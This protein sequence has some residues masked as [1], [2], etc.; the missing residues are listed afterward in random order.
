MGHED[1]TVFDFHTCSREMIDLFPDL[2]KTFIVDTIQARLFK[3]CAIMILLGVYQFIPAL[4]TLTLFQDYRCVRI[5][6]A[7][8]FL[9]SCPPKFKCY[10]V[11]TYIKK[12][13]HSMFSMTSVYLIL[14]HITS[15]FFFFSVLHLEIE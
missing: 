1:T 8:C 2:T 15:I 5:K 11:L 7:N 4:M 14:R 9:V 13:R 3:L 10:M 12:I 6:T